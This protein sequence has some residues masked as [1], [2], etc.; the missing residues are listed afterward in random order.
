MMEMTRLARRLILSFSLTLVSCLTLN[1]WGI[2]QESHRILLSPP[3]IDDFP[4]ISFYVSIYN[5][6]GE[7]L[8]NLKPE[9]IT[10]FED[11]VSLQVKELNPLYPGAQVVFAIT[12]GSSFWIRDARGNSRF[13]Y[14]SAALQKW[15]EGRITSNT[16][17][18]SL[19][20]SNG[21]EVTHLEKV[22]PLLSVL[23]SYQPDTLQA[24]PNLDTL[25]RAFEIAADRSLRPGMGR[26]VIW[27]TAPLQQDLTPAVQSMIARYKEQGVRLF[28]WF[29]ASA[30]QFAL[31]NV[32]Q[33]ANLALESGGTLFTFSGKESLP[34]LEEM[35]E[36]LRNSYFLTYESQIANSGVHQIIVQVSNE[37]FQI[38]STPLEFEIEVLP[39][40]I[41]FISPPTRIQR[42][43]P[44]EQSDNPAEGMPLSQTLE[45][46]IEFPDGHERP[47][48]RT[49]LYV[50]GEIADEN[51]TPPFDRFTWNLEKYTVTGSHTLKAEITDSLGLTN[52]SVEHSILVSIERPSQSLMVTVSRNRTVL[53]IIAAVLSGIVL[54]L[55]LVLGGRIHP[56]SAPKRKARLKPRHIDP[57]TQPVRVRST[58]TVPSLST[59]LNRL[60]LTQQPA[61]PKVYAYLRRMTE[62]NSDEEFTPIAIT[63]EEVTFG[64]DPT[65]AF[66][67]LNHPSVKALHARMTR[68]QDGS[69]KIQDEGTTAGTW[70]NYTPVP[71]E[72]ALLEDG[73]LIHIGGLGFRF[74]LTTPTRL[75]K[76]V[77]H[78]EEPPL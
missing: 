18:L 21:P 68:L 29:V 39:P 66:V 23:K 25:A 33:L 26:A 47:I 5:M 56:S 70:V 32:S 51:T 76:P 44:E 69:F 16:D 10:V 74:S 22:D 58:P 67:V 64:S 55:V 6:Q 61:A 34:N 77:V 52:S 2:A 9:N 78:H 3:E 31:P 19:L 11:G 37:E 8:H 71:P 38:N 48:R 62:K 42:L 14:V 45:V 1:P 13:D 72:G 15:I 40:N 75:R 49:V 30:E 63:K 36:P 43:T 24:N 35:L 27:I 50:D 65:Q 17:D 12:P 41:A 28:I 54:L 4:R 60:H 20:V 53:A 57:V 7:F 73:D 59:W 46:L